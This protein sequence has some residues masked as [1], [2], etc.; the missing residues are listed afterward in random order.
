MPIRTCPYCCHKNKHLIGC[1]R[2]RP[3][4][5]PRCPGLGMAATVE[6]RVSNNCPTIG[7]GDPAKFPLA[8]LYEHG[9]PD[10]N[11]WVKNLYGKYGDAQR[12]PYSQFGANPPVYAA[13]SLKFE[14]SAYLSNPL[15][16]CRYWSNHIN[17]F[18]T[19]TP[20]ACVKCSEDYAG[21]HY[22][23]MC[24]YEGVAPDN[25]TKIATMYLLTGWNF[26]GD[27]FDKEHDASRWARWNRCNQKV[28]PG[29]T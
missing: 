5:V 17:D 3:R 8:M 16:Y 19:G 2:K 18:V 20:A 23:Q 29:C 7:D 11:T 15:L 22:V 10:K 14:P 13:V 1:A 25:I 6:Y 21:P 4:R 28:D 9:M 24:A 27:C 12:V 26:A